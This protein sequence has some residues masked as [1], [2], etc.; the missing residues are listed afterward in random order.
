MKKKQIYTILIVLC[1]LI[2]GIVS[3][4]KK[5]IK[6]SAQKAYLQ[7]LKNQANLDVEQQ[8]LTLQ[9]IIQKDSNFSEP[10]T[11]LANNLTQKKK[12]SAALTTFNKLFLID[13]LIYKKNSTQIAICYA[14]IGDFNKAYELLNSIDSKNGQSNYINRLKKNYLF[15]ILNEE[16]LNN[17]TKIINLPIN[18][19]HDEYYGFNNE[20]TQNFYF[21]QRKN[22]QENWFVAGYK[23]GT[24]TNVEP[25]N[26]FNIYTDFKGALT[27]TEDNKNLYFAADLGNQ[28]GFGNVDI[29]VCNKLIEGWSDPQNLGKNINSPFWDSSP[30]VNVEN[31]FMIF[32]SD[33]PGGYGGKDLYYCYILK[34]GNWSKPINLGPTINTEK[35]EMYPYIHMDNET[36]YF[37]SNGLAGYGGTDVFIT[38]KLKDSFTNPINLGY[39]INTI[40]NEGALRVDKDGKT[41]F[42][43][44]DN[45][46]S[47]GGLD[48]FK[49]TLPAL[50]QAR[51]LQEIQIIN[52]NKIVYDTNKPTYTKPDS[53]KK[54]TTK[55]KQ[56]KYKI[57][58][59]II[60]K[61]IYFATDS[62]NLTPNNDL[63]LEDL[64]I[65][66]KTNST[67]KIR[68]EGYTDNLGDSAYNMLLSL[69]RA[70][71]IKQYLIKNQIKENSIFIKGMGASNPINTNTTEEGRKL[72]R[73]IEITILEQ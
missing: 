6:K 22:N 14:G 1:C 71:S 36:I 43:N 61:N 28:I 13:S 33:R 62:F 72:N 57:N 2:N 38:H 46:N 8:I 66:L 56:I 65:Y 49:I 64:I 10:I 70:N 63:F 9:Q 73:R 24:F 16:K 60:L 39:P 7:F 18:T 45:T 12:Y 31:N 21:T 50:F 25:F 69:K 5:E 23:N 51:N 20:N 44:S 48:I 26:L 53:L 37:T 59:P 4:Q 35:D 15:A 68:I 42:Y 27:I 3:A 34:S 19:I 30:T 67:K 54:S 58:E 17:N 52:D 32:S 41:A 40:D 47:I 11:I 55:D 29:Y